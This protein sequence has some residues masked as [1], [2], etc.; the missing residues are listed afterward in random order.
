VIGTVY[1]AQLGT[2]GHA[3]SVL[4]HGARTDTVAGEGLRA[5]DL[6]T[7]E[8]TH[9][10]ATVIDRSSR[11]TFDLVLVAVRRDHLEAAAQDLS[12]LSGHPLILFFG[13]NPSGAAGLPSGLPGSAQMGFPG[14]GGALRGAVGEYVR[15]PQQPTALPASP[16]PELQAL[17]AALESRGFPVQRVTDMSG[18]LAYHA[19]FVA[20]ISAALYRCGSDPRRL[21][22]DRAVLKLMCRAIT[23]GFG[24]LGSRGITGL[25][26]NLAVLHSRALQPVA[27][28]YWARSMRSPMGEFAFA[29][30]ARHAEPEMKALARDI[31]SAVVRDGEPASMLR[32]LTPSRG[33]ARPTLDACAIDLLPSGSGRS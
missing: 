18:W 33:S 19:V 12:T 7:G 22:D 30:H 10:P 23:D 17:Q 1:G 26:R 6:L 4:A 20:S 14:V 8:D 13:N 5:H 32:L 2:A 11:D 9:A 3:V 29:A 16:R 25:P 21:A 15:V 28:R 27:V 24:A 31:L